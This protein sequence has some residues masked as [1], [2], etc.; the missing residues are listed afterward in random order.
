MIISFNRSLLEVSSTGAYIKSLVLDGEKIINDSHD[1]ND[2]HGG[3]AVLFPFGNRIR[4]AEYKY[5]NINYKLPK[6][7]G[8]N[9]IH[10]LVRDK[11]FN[12]I[13]SCNKIEFFMDFNDESYPGNAF[14]N[15]SYILNERSFRTDFTVTSKN[16]KIP[17]EIGF[18]P[19]F[20]FPDKCIFRSGKIMMLNYLD[21][22]FPDGTLSDTSINGSDISKLSIDNCFYVHG[23]VIL[24]GNK[25]IRIDRENMDYLVIYTG[26]YEKTKSIAVE[27]MT[28]APDVYNNKIG[29]IELNKG[30]S[31]HC[32][33][34]IN[35]I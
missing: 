21:E 13:V 34:T 27:P 29:L 11:I 23:P 6:N 18:H 28:G 19:Y 10:G 22:Y 15:V 14:I 12:V 24:E 33:Y 31:F 7:N 25:K 20:Y 17:V 1:G 4:N 35:L 32:S 5:N 2:T 9:S 16:E 3:S 26:L 30:E 8:E